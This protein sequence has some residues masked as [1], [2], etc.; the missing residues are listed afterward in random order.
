MNEKG[1]EDGIMI[2]RRVLATK[3][4]SVIDPIELIP[5]SSSLQIIRSI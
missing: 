5:S 4:V 3:K 2:E 1:I